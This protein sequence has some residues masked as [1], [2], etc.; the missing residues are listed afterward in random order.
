MRLR[1]LSH[2]NLPALLDAAVA[3]ADPLEVMPPVEAPP[4]WTDGRRTAFLDFHRSRSLDATDPVETTYAVQVDGRVVG[5]ARLEPKPEGVEIGL[6]PGRSHRGRGI[7]GEVLTSLA[8]IARERGYTQMLASTTPENTAARRLLDQAGARVE[9][10]AV[11]I[12]AVVD[13]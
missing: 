8:V 3:D 4:G 6:W 5:A 1:A 10:D 12:E 7:G 2:R 13:L 9:T 11:T